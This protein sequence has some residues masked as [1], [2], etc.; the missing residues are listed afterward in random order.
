MSTTSQLC[1]EINELSLEYLAMK[2]DLIT[3]LKIIS[4]LVTTAMPTLKIPPF[5]L[6]QKKQADENR[7]L[8]QTL[9]DEKWED[10]VYFS[11]LESNVKTVKTLY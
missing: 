10:N 4:K 11:T 7:S 8:A 2:I 1:L 9:Y 6:Q 5:S 3:Q